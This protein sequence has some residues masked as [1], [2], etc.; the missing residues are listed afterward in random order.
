MRGFG[1]WV[2]SFGKLGW[3]F[4]RLGAGFDDELAGGGGEVGA[5]LVARVVFFFATVR[6]VLPSSFLMRFALAG[7]LSSR[8]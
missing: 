6:E 1:V 8:I 3:N 7:D 5:A 2:T 4:D